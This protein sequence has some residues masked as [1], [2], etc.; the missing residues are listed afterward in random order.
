MSEQMQTYAF[1]ACVVLS[2]LI[3]TSRDRNWLYILGPTEKVLPEDGDRT[4]SEMLLCINKNRAM[5][6]V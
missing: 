4:V 2:G 5:D 3:T 6:N 1:Q